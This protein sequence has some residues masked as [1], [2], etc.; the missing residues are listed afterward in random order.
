MKEKRYK[1]SRI[2]E[3]ESLNRVTGNALKR[4][5]F[6]KDVRELAKWYSMWKKTESIN[7]TF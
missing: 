4:S 5:S 3:T 2:E 6:L 1:I 7:G